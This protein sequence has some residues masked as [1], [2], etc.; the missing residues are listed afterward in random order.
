MSGNGMTQAGHHPACSS[1]IDH[2]PR[3]WSGRDYVK[4]IQLR[5]NTLPTQDAPYKPRDQRRC[6]AG[7]DRNE[8][9][10]HILQRCPVTHWKR[11][12]RHDWVVESTA[13]WARKK[14]MNVLVEPHIRDAD[15]VL[16]KPDL[17]FVREGEVIV[18]DVAIC[19]E[20][21]RPLETS[22]D[23]KRAIYS[24][25]PFLDAL[26]A[27]YPDSSIRVLPYIIGARGTWCRGNRFLT[28]AL[29]MPA[30][31][32]KDH[33]LSVLKTGFIIHSEFMRTV[34]RTRGAAV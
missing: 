8:S 15:G 10:C 26:R 14:G 1:F 22:A 4:A 24:G 20:G 11:I 32:V 25:G 27:R 33:I 2:P 3:Y 29:R 17:L 16:H 5:T 28:E 6:R 31:L 34:W 21:P 12:Q 30:Y 23:I 9:L 18:S 7:C 19:W 13:K